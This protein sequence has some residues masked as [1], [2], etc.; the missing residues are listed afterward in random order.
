MKPSRLRVSVFQVATSSP[1]SDGTLEWD[2]TVMVTAEI[3]REGQT[4][5]GYT[6]AD[7]ATAHFIEE[8]LAGIILA[9]DPQAVESNFASMERAVRNVGRDGVAA[10]A[11][12]ALDMAGWDL[13][14][15]LNGQSFID[16]IGPR[17]TSIDA[18]GSGGFTSYTPE[19]LHRQLAGWAEQG[20]TRV[21]MKIGADS[22]TVDRVRLAREAIGPRVELFVDANGAY[23]PKEA[24]GLADRFAA[25][26]LGVV[27]FEE[28]V[29]SDDLEGLAFVRHRA[30]HA[31]S[32]A[33]GEYGY[34]ARTFE[35]MLA[36]GAVDVLQADATRCGITGFLTAAA[37][38]EARGVP[39]SAHC[40]PTVHGHIACVAP[41]VVHV[42][43][44]HDH[45]CLEPQLLE[46]A[47]VASDGVL[48][49]DPSRSG[50]G[51]S[52]RRADAERYLV[53]DQQV[54]RGP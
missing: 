37:S 6:Y 33:A 35:R 4:G 15:K 30:P 46:G 19:E 31:M 10:T 11:I 45:A 50:F 24:L 16:L 28:P 17:R 36:A 48:R 32:I 52:L 47:L 12:A 20:F 5:F 13:K 39:L 29:S 8:H 7:V 3:T 23:A 22:S 38:C 1:E 14:A 40:A 26:G 25:A 9:A 49:P 51:L 34:R 27:W 21:K 2:K 44:F 53:F 54:D 41:R 42:E 43:Y 18:Y